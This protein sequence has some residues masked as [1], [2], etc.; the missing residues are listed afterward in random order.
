M[1]QS[2]VKVGRYYT[3]KSGKIRCVTRVSIEQAGKEYVHWWPDG[4]GE[5]VALRFHKRQLLKS[6]AKWAAGE[7]KPL[8]HSVVRCPGCDAW[9]WWSDLYSEGECEHCG[10]PCNMWKG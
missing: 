3:G 7:V 4:T 10:T 2:E 6:F 9:E 5:D 1:K 8:Y